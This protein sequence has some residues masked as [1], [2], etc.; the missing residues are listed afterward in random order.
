M[1]REVVENAKKARKHRDRAAVFE[2]ITLGAFVALIILLTCA[3]IAPPPWEVH[4]SMF[5]LADR[6]LAGMG[7]CA[8]VIALKYGH[9]ATIAIGN[10]KIALDGNG[11]GKVKDESNE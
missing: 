3:A 6:I 4:E 10:M 1:S 11:D 5:R 9:D 2:Y 7:I 8:G